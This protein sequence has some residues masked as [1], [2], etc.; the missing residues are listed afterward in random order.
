M[1]FRAVPSINECV[2]MFSDNSM[3][4]VLTWPGCETG[5]R[6]LSNCVFFLHRESYDGF[7]SNCV[8][9]RAVRGRGPRS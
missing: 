6:G 5:T 9:M 1:R 2:K 4:F 7:L 3:V 8:Q